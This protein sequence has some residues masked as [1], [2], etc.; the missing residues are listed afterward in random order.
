MIEYTQSAAPLYP[1]L[2]GGDAN[3]Y[4]MFAEGAGRIVKPEGIV[5]LLLTSNIAADQGGTVS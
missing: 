5:T 1:V 2:G 4:A 3:L